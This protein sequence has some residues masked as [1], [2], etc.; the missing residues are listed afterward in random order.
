[1]QPDCKNEQC[2]YPNPD[3][4]RF[5]L[6]CPLCC[7]FGSATRICRPVLFSALFFDVLQAKAG[8]HTGISRIL[9]SLRNREIFLLNQIDVV[10]QSME[11]L[12]AEHERQLNSL[13]PSSSRPSTGYG[14][15]EDG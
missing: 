15:D 6:H 10:H 11:D 2:M 14:S 7:S 1:M 9:E 13:G 4:V 5:F 8:V 3:M 12:L